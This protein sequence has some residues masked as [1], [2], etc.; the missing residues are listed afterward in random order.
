[1]EWS[2][3]NLDE[4]VRMLKL[5]V[6]EYENNAEFYLSLGQIEEQR[7]NTGKA[8]EWYSNGLNF[9]P[10]SVELWINM[11]HLEERTSSAAEA[12]AR[13]DMA[14]CMNSCNVQLWLE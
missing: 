14:R 6:Q 5:G 8:K 11:A 10:E 4:A 12:R 9:N 1:L 3:E 13:L 2:L 7:G